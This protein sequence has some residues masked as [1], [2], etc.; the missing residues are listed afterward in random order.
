M[1]CLLLELQ[2]HEGRELQLIN[3][4]W[5]IGQTKPVRVKRVVAAGT[6][7]ERMLHLRKRSRGLMAVDDAAPKCR[8]AGDQFM[9]SISQ[10][11]PSC[12]GVIHPS[13]VQ[14]SMAVSRVGDSGEDAPRGG[15][16]AAP[17]AAAHA[18]A[19]QAVRDDDLRYLDGDGS[20]C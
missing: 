6:I 2:G 17:A 10:T 5:R 1:H 3:R 18:A 8:C 9:P 4:V 15:K 16:A 14:D 7:E 12:C 11:K 20:S 13:G 19:Q